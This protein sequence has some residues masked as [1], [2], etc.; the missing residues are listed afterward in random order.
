MSFRIL[1]CVILSPSLC[2]SERSEGSPFSTQD[3]LC[4]ESPLIAQ[5]KLREESRL[6]V[7]I[8]TRSFVSLRMTRQLHHAIFIKVVLQYDLT[9]VML[10]F[11]CQVKETHGLQNC[12]IWIAGCVIRLAE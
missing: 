4:E 6:F 3:R 9:D 10:N 11:S 12:L 7:S 1:H 2:H 8:K 5:D